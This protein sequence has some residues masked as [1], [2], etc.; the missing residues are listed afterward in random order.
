MSLPDLLKHIYHN[1]TDEVIRRGKKIFHTG[2]VQILESDH[3]T[4]TV[5][6][7]VRNDI[8]YNH[9]KVV[10]ENYGNGSKLS[11]RCQCPYNMGIVC[12]HEAAALF[13]LNDLLQSGYFNHVKIDYDQKHTVVRMRQIT[14]HFLKL[15]SD[16]LL[17]D[18]AADLVTGDHVDILEGKNGVV[19]AEVKVGKKIFPILLKQNEERFFDTSC[20][21]DEKRYP[22]CIHKVAG[23]LKLY[24]AHGE[25]YFSTIRDWDAEKNKLLALYGYS[26]ED[27]LKG[28]FAFSFH[29]G[30]LSMRVLNPSIKKI[31]LQTTTP[32]KT[33]IP[34]VPQDQRMAVVIEAGAKSF[35]NVDFKLISG[36]ANEANDALKGKVEEL[37]VNQYISSVGLNEEEKNLINALRK[38]NTEEL[39]KSLKRDSPFGDFW[40][41]LPKELKEGPSQELQHQIWEFYWPKYTNFVKQFHEF[42]FIYFLE[43]GKNLVARNIQKLQLS[44]KNFKVQVFVRP[45]SKHKEN[46]DIA[47][48]LKIAIEEDVLDFKELNILNS[49]LIL[50]K[51]SL[52][53]ADYVATIQAL[54][55]FNKK[56]AVAIPTAQWPAFLENTLLPLSD[57]IPVEFD[58]SLIV[59]LKIKEPHIQLE[60][61]ET[62]K[63][64]VFKPLFV[65]GD[66]QKEWLDFEP[67]KKSANGKVEIQ[68]R[69]EPAEQSFLT[70][71]RH[72]HPSMQESRKAAAFWL[73]SKEAMQG[74]WYFE[75]MDKLQ[76]KEIEV[77]GYEKLKQLKINPN[78]PITK[79]QISSGI[80]WFDAKIDV[81]FGDEKVSLA[82]IKKAFN[83]KQN[84]ITLSDNS[85]GLLPQEWMEKY[86]LMIK[87]GNVKSANELKLKKFHFSA[88]DSV[89]DEIQEADVLEHIMEKRERLSSFDYGNHLNVHIPDNVQAELRPYQQA[90]FQWMNFLEET[91]W[92]GILADDMGLGKTLQTLTILQHYQNLNPDALFLVV[93]PTT[94]MYNWQNELKKYTPS[95]SFQIHHGPQRTSSIETLKRKNLIITSYGTLRSDI[96]LLEQMEFDYIVLDESQTIKNPL[97]LVAKASL[98]LKGKNKLALS[99]TPVQNNTF[100]LYAQMNFLNPGMLGTM[101]FFRNEFATPI[102]K[103]QEQEAKENLRRLIHPFLMRRTKEQVAPDLPEKSEVIMYCEMG[104]KQRKI[105]ELYKNSFRARILGEIDERGLGKVQLS[106]LTGLMKLRQICDSPA[107]LN[108]EEYANENH[109]IKIQE[110]MRS[111]LENTGNHKSLV[112]SQFLGML[113]L[114]REELE[115]QKIPYVYFDGGTSSADRE[116]AITDFQEKDDVR[117]FLISL[118]AGGVGLNLTAADYVY[119]VDPWWNPAVEQQAIDRTHRIGQTKNIFAYRMICKDTIEEKILLLQE[120]KLSLVKD[121]VNEENAFLKK[122]TKEDIEYLLS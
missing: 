121:L 86:S 56:P 109:S 78:K 26:L 110:L 68:Q 99:G 28:K 82:A 13:Q 76:Q 91:G 62:E 87:L 15:F 65:Y 37:D 104:P 25:N 19:K 103:N 45:L 79:L 32:E 39:I 60:L 43:E 100:D 112:F 106:V 108:D 69:D 27:D 71:M 31:A 6:F 36:T 8:Y 57:S 105:Y 9:Y 67:I 29:E 85:L 95:I 44:E 34:E 4:E 54:A 63:T 42:P 102:D 50:Y 49:G 61:K 66:V 22:L 53:V 38:I 98:R 35:P 7:R 17:F 46:S 111:I 117:V 1:A 83:K 81:Q 51:Q 64:L 33:V 80:D 58:D 74:N 88:L 47:M 94:L 12:R 55:L 72:L 75:F 11:T 92:G 52:Y 40:D 2:G 89:K 73:N 116:K 70:F 120:R 24:H 14:T 107:I 18:Q 90:G 96:A 41:S 77:V 114:I 16:R 84:F 23:F 10:V 101:E 122:L 59:N 30:R 113:H 20:T 48:Q 118:K 115:K 93:C 5:T 97:S 3:L 119:I 21:C